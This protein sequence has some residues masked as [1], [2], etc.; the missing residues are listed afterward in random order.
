MFK[1]NKMHDLVPGLY[2]KPLTLIERVAAKGKNTKWFCKCDLCGREVM[3]LARVLA[4]GGYRSCGCKNY[5]PRPIKHGRYGSLEYNSWTSMKQRCK[6]GTKYH[7]QGIRIC[8][9]WMDF[10]NFFEDMGVRLSSSHSLDRIKVT[11]GYMPGNCRW[12]TPEEQSNNR[13]ATN[14]ITHNGETKSL[15]QWAR[16][17]GL[18]RS[19]LCSRLRHGDSF[20]D[21]ISRPVFNSHQTKLMQSTP[22]IVGVEFSKLPTNFSLDG[23]PLIKLARDFLR[24]CVNLEHAKSLLEQAHREGQDEH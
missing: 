17:A 6:P 24:V 19:T 8:K 18:T 10:A 13:T 21:A 14:L 16:H 9:R 2:L 20:A 1:V 22:K 11:E 12:A 3:L 5:N 23:V 15:T 4:V 7:K